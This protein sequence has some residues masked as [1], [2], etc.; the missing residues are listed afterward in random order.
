MNDQHPEMH[1]RITA[2][3]LLITTA[4]QIS[5]Q[6]DSFCSWLL[7]GVGGAYALIFSNLDSLQFLV[8]SSSLQTSLL[9]LLVAIVLGVLQRWLAAIVASNVAASEKAEKL[10]SELAE[11]NL[12]IDFRI[13][14]QE[15]EKGLHFPSNLIARRSFEKVLGGDFAASGRL[16][17]GISQ[18]QSLF[19]LVLVG[20]VVAAIA[21]TALGLK[22]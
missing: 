4:G 15:V 18:L 22:T 2:G 10:G 8:S 11:R 21:V 7:L 6:L 17:A 20:L 19:V 3:R 16:T 1:E 12:Q 14:F 13:V 5:M 9:L